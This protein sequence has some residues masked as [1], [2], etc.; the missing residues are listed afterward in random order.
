MRAFSHRTR[1]WSCQRLRGWSRP[2]ALIF[3]VE[4]LY[5]SKAVVVLRFGTLVSTHSHTGTWSCYGFAG[6]GF[7]GPSG[8]KLRFASAMAVCLLLLLLLL[9]SLLLLPLENQKCAIEKFVTIRGSGRRRRGRM[10]C[11]GP[12]ARRGAGRAPVGSIVR[13]AAG[14]GWVWRAQTAFLSKTANAKR[15]RRAFSIINSS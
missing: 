12:R 5:F 2:W 13:P 4:F 10:A 8:S 3:S 7:L 1:F 14:R 11:D 9:Q 6:K 15:A